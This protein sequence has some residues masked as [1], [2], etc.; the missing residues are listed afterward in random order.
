MTLVIKHPSILW[1]QRAGQ[2]FLTIE[3]GDLKIDELYCEDDKFKLKGEKGGNKYEADL[4]LFGKLKGAERRKIETDRRIEFVIPKE[5]EEWWPRLLKVSGKVPWIKVDFDKW[6]DQD[7][8][9]KD[10]MRDMDFSSFGLPGGGVGKGY[11]DLDLGDD[12]HDYDDEM[13]D[14]EDADDE[15]EGMP[16]EGKQVEKNEGGTDE[17]NIKDK[18]KD[19]A[20]NGEMVDE[21]KEKKVKEEGKE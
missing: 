9:D 20:T 1:A 7:E 17:L 13:G 12:D 8:D 21:E 16:K 6:K 11:D 19:S 14:L 2:V 5:T 3:D 4:D 15:N 18:G 10:D